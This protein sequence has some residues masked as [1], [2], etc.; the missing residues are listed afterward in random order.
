M[1]KIQEKI[2]EQIEVAMKKFDL[3]PNRLKFTTDTF[4]PDSPKLETVVTVDVGLRDGKSKELRT[5][6]SFY[7]PKTY[8][9]S[10]VSKLKKEIEQYLKNKR[11]KIF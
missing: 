8:H 7:S 1:K 6:R 5:I 11:L 10:S 9:V 4:K 2:D 3:P